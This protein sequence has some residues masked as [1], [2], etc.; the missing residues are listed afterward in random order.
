LSSNKANFFFVIFLQIQLLTNI[1]LKNHP[2]LIRLKEQKEEL[3]DLLKLSKETLLLR[4]FNYHLK[5]ANHPRRVTNFDKDLA[6]G[7]NYVILLN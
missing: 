3:E 1:D 7:E 6:D 4:W 5:N 2:Y